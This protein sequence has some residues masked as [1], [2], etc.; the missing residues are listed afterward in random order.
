MTSPGATPS[1]PA[2]GEPSDDGSGVHAGAGAVL[3]DIDGTLVDSN[4]LHV[5]AWTQAFADAGH[6]VDAWR[7]QRAIGMGSAQ[8]LSELLGDDADR[9]ED[10]V[11]QGHTDRYAQMT[12]LLRAFG[13]ARDLV[14]AVSD[15]GAVVVLAT[16]APPDELERLR[17]V[18]DLDDTLDAITGAEDVEAAKPEPDL[19]QVALEKAGCP[20][21]SSVF[22][23]DSR[24]D[25]VAA[26]R[27]GVPCVGL[28]SGG[29]SA[30]DLTEAGAVAVYDD[31][32]ALLADLDASPL[33]VTWRG[34]TA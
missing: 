12:P 3:F 2:S 15:R 10:E 7:T 8:L 29:T 32:A 5:H 6:P 26:A 14:Q 34:S 16:S 4:F 9:L 31:V 27:A 28:L 30:A 13:G 20:A 22:V 18:L 25:V 21:A 33:A 11:K 23:G 24:W 19:V 17:A 1:T